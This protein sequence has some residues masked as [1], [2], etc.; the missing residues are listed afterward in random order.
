MATFFKARRSA[1]TPPQ[2]LENDPGATHPVIAA[3][4]SL[5]YPAATLGN[6]EFNYGLEVLERAYAGAHFPVVCAN[7]RRRDGSDWFPPSVVVERIVFDNSGAAR[8]LRVGVI[9]FA[10]PQIAQW[11]E[12]HVRGRL[13]TLD[14]VEA[15]AA[16]VRALKSRVD[17]IVALCHSGISRLASKLGEENAGLD[18]ARIEGIDALFLGHQHLLLPGDDFAG[19]TGVDAALRNHSRAS[20]LSWPASGA[21]TSASSISSCGRTKEAWEV[22][23]QRSRSRPIARR[24]ARRRRCRACRFGRFCARGGEERAHAARSAMCARPWERLPLPSTP[25]WR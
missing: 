24:D 2:R 6:H 19:I 23:D 7:I 17:L 18:L 16:E 22:V 14:I 13:M 5:D 11:D 8:T 21:A 10:P 25:I 12:T 9:G 15:A 20:R 4:N 1:T 3:M